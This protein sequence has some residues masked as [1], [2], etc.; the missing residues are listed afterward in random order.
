MNPLVETSW[1]IDQK[2]PTARAQLKELDAITSEPYPF[3]F[4]DQF[5]KQRLSHRVRRQIE[6]HGR[7]TPILVLYNIP[8][9]D[10][11]HHSRGG[12]KNGKEYLEF[13]DAFAEGIGNSKPIVILEPDALASCQ[14]MKIPSRITRIKTIRDAISILIDKTGAM[15]YVDIGNPEYIVDPV[16]AGKI[17]NDIGIER[18]CGFALNVSNYYA[19]DLCEEYGRQISKATNHGS[20]FIIDTSRNGVG[21]IS[22]KHWCNA[23]DRRLGTAPTTGVYEPLC[24]AYLWVKPPAE[25]DGPCNGGPRAGML[26]VEYGKMLCGHPYNLNKLWDKN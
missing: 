18:T 13:V 16:A 19:T 8:Q 1:F 2:S 25:S 14:N 20:H 26:W 17:L 24:D 6:R 3:W 4:T 12:A 9:R 22:K 10:L 5:K 7:H 23:V 21:N 11:G 15:V